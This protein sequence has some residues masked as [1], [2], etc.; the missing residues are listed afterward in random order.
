ML[1]SIFQG[2]DDAHLSIYIYIHVYILT[3]EGKGESRRKEEPGRGRV[4]WK[5]ERE[6]ER[7]SIK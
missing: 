6:G 5:G 3:N 1:E 7:E 4:A 2:D